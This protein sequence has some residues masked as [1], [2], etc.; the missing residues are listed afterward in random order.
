MVRRVYVESA[1][2]AGSSR[3]LA[4]VEPPNLG[5]SSSRMDLWTCLEAE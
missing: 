2:F 4:H 1:F 3:V 5:R